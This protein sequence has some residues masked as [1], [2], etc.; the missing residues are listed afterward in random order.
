MLARIRETIDAWVAG[1][2]DDLPETGTK[3]PE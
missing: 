2:I 1:Q 3:F